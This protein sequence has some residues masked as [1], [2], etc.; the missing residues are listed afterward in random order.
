[1]ETVKDVAAILGIAF[2]CLGVIGG[3]LNLPTAWSR[4]RRAWHRHGQRGVAVLTLEKREEGEH[5]YVRY[6]IAEDLMQI[7]EGLSKRELGGK[8]L[9]IKSVGDYYD[10][11]ME[12]PRG[13]EDLVLV[14]KRR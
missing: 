11:A 13:A 10:V 6:L 2:V 9:H 8:Y 4:F 5:L 12:F 7:L 14:K 1:M 3:L